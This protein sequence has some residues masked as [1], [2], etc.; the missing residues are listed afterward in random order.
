MKVFRTRSK[1]RNFW[2]KPSAKKKRS[3]WVTKKKS[4]KRSIWVPKTQ[5]K[6]KRSIWATKQPGKAQYR[7]VYK[8][9]QLQ[10]NRAKCVKTFRDPEEAESWVDDKRVQFPYNAYKV[11]HVDKKKGW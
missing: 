1:K 8:V 3:I 4:P 10:G 6:E 7:T 9:Y 11:S 2:A 5:K